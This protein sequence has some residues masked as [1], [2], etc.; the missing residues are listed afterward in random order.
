MVRAHHGHGAASTDKQYQTT[1]PHGAGPDECTSQSR[2]SWHPTSSRSAYWQCVTR[3]RHRL[4]TSRLRLTTATRARA[5]TP[6]RVRSAR[7]PATGRPPPGTGKSGRPSCARTSFHHM[8]G[9]S[10]RASSSSS[11]YWSCAG[12]FWHV[13]GRVIHEITQLAQDDARM[14]G[15]WTGGGRAPRLFVGMEQRKPH[16]RADADTAAAE[17]RCQTAAAAAAAAAAATCCPEAAQEEE[18]GWR[19]PP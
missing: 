5:G 9:G 19:P 3:G 15:T 4:G 18:P 1:R 8:D 6:Y 11:Q 7:C 17:N 14:P 13:G 2:G 12:A 16:A 10:R